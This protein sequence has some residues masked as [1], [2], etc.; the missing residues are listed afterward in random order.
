MAT[1]FLNN[2]NNSKD[3]LSVELK[4][5][6]SEKLNLMLGNNVIIDNDIKDLA[7]KFL[8]QKV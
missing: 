7:L 3:N 1:D 5:S 8:D 4:N 2:L 6:I